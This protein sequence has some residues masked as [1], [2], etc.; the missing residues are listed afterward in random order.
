VRLWNGR[1]EQMITVYFPNPWL[2]DDGER[3]REPRWERTA[4]W[5]AL[6]RRYAGA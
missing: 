5:D 1:G 4:L 6:K 3:V 2:D